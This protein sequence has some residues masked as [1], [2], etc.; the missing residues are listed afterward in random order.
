[1][2]AGVDVGRLVGQVAGM[3][4]VFALTLFLS[5]GT[6]AW[7]AAWW[8]LI[9]YF[10]FVV[11]LS[12][13][14]LRHNPGLLNERMGG[15]RADQKAWDKALLVLAAGLF[16]AWLVLMPL[17]AVRFGWS[18]IP[19]WLQSVGALSL[20]A[21]FVVFFLTFRANAYLSPVVRIQTDRGQ[22]VISTGPYRYVRHPMYA[23][24][25]LFALGTALLLGSWYGG[26]LGLVLVVV[27]ARRAVLE[28]RTLRAELAGYEAYMARVRY[29]LIPHVW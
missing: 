16:F 2:N 28:E 24:F 17:D 1:M 10:G 5:A 6:L 19:V 26:L 7:P 9:L 3:F 29:R 4:V 22:T 18:H 8:F 13:W 11:A 21:S 25:V 15:F 20:L 14:L 27:V 23:G 12:G